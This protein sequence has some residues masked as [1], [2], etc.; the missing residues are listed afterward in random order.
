MRQVL[1]F[2]EE[3]SKRIKIYESNEG[4]NIGDLSRE[5][6]AELKEWDM[7]QKDDC[8][9]AFR[10]G[11]KK[12]LLEEGT[13]DPLELHVYFTALL[14]NRTH[15]EE[16]GEIKALYQQ[17]KL[18]IESKTN[19]Y[20]QKN[21]GV[22]IVSITSGLP[23][24]LNKELKGM[25]PKH[26]MLAKKE[27]EEYLSVIFGVLKVKMSDNRIAFL[28]DSIEIARSVGYSKIADKYDS[29]LS[30]LISRKD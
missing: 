3:G 11:I 15:V 7:L 13:S 23:D 12:R 25:F 1:F 10:Q 28:K 2:D 27:H 29:L 26:T 22:R 18:D 16:E 4:Y 8:Y 21:P 17:F 6:F 5:A 14:K 30:D 24:Y 9:I 19:D 20:S